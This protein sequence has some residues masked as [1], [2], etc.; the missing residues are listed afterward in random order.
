MAETSGSN[1]T[2]S[3]IY[4]NL[5]QIS[6]MKKIKF[7]IYKLEISNFEKGDPTEKN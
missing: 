4:V 2:L 1:T 7:A 3:H 6:F 5:E